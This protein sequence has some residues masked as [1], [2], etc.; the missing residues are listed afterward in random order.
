MP[1]ETATNIYEAEN[2]CQRQNA[3]M[4]EGLINATECSN[5]LEMVFFKKKKFSV[6]LQLQCNL[7]PL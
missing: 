6:S 7:I 3:S 5:F 2:L 4:H 1:N